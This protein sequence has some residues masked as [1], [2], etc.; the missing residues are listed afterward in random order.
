[1]KTMITSMNQK[2]YENYGKRFIE[3]WIEKSSNDTKLIVSFEGDISEEVNSIESEKVKIISINSAVYNI[4]R[5]KFGS[6]SEANGL[7]YAKNIKMPG[8]ASFS[9]NFRYDAMR[10]SFKVFSIYKCL[11]LELIKNDF[12]WIDADVVCLKNFSSSDLDQFFPDPNQLASYLGRDNFPKPNAYSECG[13]VGYNFEHPEIFN[14]IEDMLRQYMNGDI[15]L[16]KEWHDCYLFD[17]CR[18]QFEDKN[19]QFKNLSIDFLN[20]E[21]P[22]IKTK[23]GNFFDHLKGPTRKAVGHS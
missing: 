9:Y 20:E 14:F 7:N 5:K 15:F 18:K 23:L 3:S 6:F 11:E 19:N 21:H 10:F 2:L 22:F 1:M 17:N 4:F 8:V 12:A 13:F 16:L